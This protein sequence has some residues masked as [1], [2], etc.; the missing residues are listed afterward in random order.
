MSIQIVGLILKNNPAPDPDRRR[1]VAHFD[2][3]IS[4]LRVQGCALIRTDKGGVAMSLPN[5]DLD[6]VRRGLS[7]VDPLLQNACIAAAREAYKA[8]GGTDLP[9]WAMKPRIEAPISALQA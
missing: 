2:V 1:I 8:L 6:H 9:E 7:F 3:E 5:V 4:G